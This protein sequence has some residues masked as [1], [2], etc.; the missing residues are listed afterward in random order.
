MYTC[1][2][3]CISLSICIYLIAASA[4]GLSRWDPSV[5]MPPAASPPPRPAAA[6]SSSLTYGFY[7]RFNNLRFRQSQNLNEQHTIA[8]NIGLLAG[9]ADQGCLRRARGAIVTLVPPQPFCLR[10]HDLT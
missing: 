3:I 1:I 9:P 10:G 7:H 2:R 6:H 8:T 5:R 4:G